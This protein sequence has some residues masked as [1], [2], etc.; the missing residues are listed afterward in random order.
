MISTTDKTPR[1]ADLIVVGGG[2]AGLSAAALVAREGRSVVVLERA[3]HL[4]GRAATHVRHGVHFNLGPHALY[5]R[6]HAFRLFESL[7]VPFTGRFPDAE[8]R[9]RL[10]R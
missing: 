5:C 1:H 4:G 9:T 6:G 7:R 2:L 8:R 3:S 10:R